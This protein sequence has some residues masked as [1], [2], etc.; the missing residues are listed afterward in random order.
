MYFKKLY[1]YYIEGLSLINKQVYFIN[2]YKGN[3][4]IKY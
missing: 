2:H 4:K 3:I 1:I